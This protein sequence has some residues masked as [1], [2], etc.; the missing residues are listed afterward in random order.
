MK[1]AIYPGSFDPVTYGHLDIIAR[2]ARVFDELIVSVLDNKAKHPLF[3]VDERVNILKELTREYRNIRVESYT[4]LLV[5]C[6]LTE[7]AHVIIRGLRAVTDFEYELQMAQ[8][9]RK[10][11]GSQVDTMFLTTDLRYAYLS[12]STVKEVASFGGDITG[13]VPPIVAELTYQKYG[14]SKSAQTRK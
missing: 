10:L 12:S 13:F 4:G 1:K 7:G 9:N 8:T 3:S 5:D 14:I 6:C 11:A 2:S